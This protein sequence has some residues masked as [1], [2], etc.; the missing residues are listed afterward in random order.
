MNLESLTKDELILAM[1]RYFPGLTKTAIAGIRLQY[2]ETKAVEL[3]EC[4]RLCELAL[5]SGTL[6]DRQRYYNRLSVDVNT[7][8][9]ADVKAEI[10][11]LTE[12]YFGDVR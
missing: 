8:E 2:L 9:L 7:D 12:T 1:R 10:Q 3:T 6:T 11:R 5:A 4:V